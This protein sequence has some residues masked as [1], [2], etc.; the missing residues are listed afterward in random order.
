MDDKNM[1]GFADGS[2]VMH[3]D[4]DW[5]GHRNGDKGMIGKIPVSPFL[6]PRPPADIL[7]VSS[8]PLR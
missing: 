7:S 8:K 3:E 6:S 2:W 4:V 5:L 1:D